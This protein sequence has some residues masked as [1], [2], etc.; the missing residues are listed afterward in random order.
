MQKL[1]LGSAAGAAAWLNLPNKTEE[2][3]TETTVLKHTFS[4]AVGQRV[5]TC[6]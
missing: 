2:L 4:R 5:A 3:K 1:R 6:Y